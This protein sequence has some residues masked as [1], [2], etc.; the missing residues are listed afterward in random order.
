MANNP[1]NLAL[2][3]VLELTGL[4]AMGYWVWTQHSGPSRWL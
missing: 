3:V 4:F 2:R 1:L